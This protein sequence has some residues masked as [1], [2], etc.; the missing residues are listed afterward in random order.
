[1]AKEPG[2]RAGISH[3]P[4]L[5]IVDSDGQTDHRRLAQEIHETTDPLLDDIESQ[6]RRLRELGHPGS[7]EIIAECRETI[8]EIRTLMS[9]LSL[10]EGA[11]TAS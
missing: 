3:E 10:N 4:G 9:A 8:D 2:N 7:E 5:R 6:L 11:P 1:M